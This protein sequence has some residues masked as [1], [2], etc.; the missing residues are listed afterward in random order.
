MLLNL[1]DRTSGFLRAIVRFS[2]WWKKVWYKMQFLRVF[3]SIHNTLS[4]NQGNVF[5]LWK[6]QI[7]IPS[8]FL[9]LERSFPEKNFKMFSGGY[10]VVSPICCVIESEYYSFGNWQLEILSSDALNN[11]IWE[12]LCARLSLSL[13]LR[14]SLS[15]RLR[16]KPKPNP[17]GKKWLK[18]V[19]F[20][21]VL[22]LG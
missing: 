20:R 2:S 16:L 10:F 11:N 15:L 8:M 4:L 18:I 9:S 17:L 13:G 1:P 14:L 22:G 7:R 21:L 3:A 5:S 12:V 6:C 19:N